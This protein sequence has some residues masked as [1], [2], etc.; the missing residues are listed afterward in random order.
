MN[1]K[2]L[3][4]VGAAGQKG[5]GIGE[6]A[7]QLA[8][9]QNR[10]GVNLYLWT[11]DDAD[12]AG[13]IREKSGLTTETLQTFP[14]LGPSRYAFSPAMVK[15][16]RDT[17]QS[18]SVVHHHGVWACTSYAAFV[19]SKSGQPGRPFILAP[20][21]ELQSW[22]LRRS[23]WKKAVTRRLYVN[24]LLR[25]TA[26]FQALG[27]H[28]VNDIRRLGL[29]N[30]VAVIPNGI[31]EEWCEQECD[32]PA[33]REKY[34][35]PK[36]K[37]IVLFLSRV[38]PKK[39]LPMLFEA[40]RRHRGR[41]SDWLCVVAGPDEFGHARELEELLDS[42]D[43]RSLVRMIGPVY[44]ADKRNA[45]AAADLFVLPSHSEGFPLA[46][47]ESLGAGVPPIV[48]KG[49]PMPFLESEACGWWPDVSAD[50]I[51]RALL[52]STAR[53][54]AELAAIGKAGERLVADK[55]TWTKVAR[56]CVELYSWLEGKGRRPE[57]VIMD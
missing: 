57:F 43:L 35:I 37:R 34:L 38:S 55:F 19:W 48:T 41:L 39:G 45:F 42:W 2:I 9:A 26:C 8:R 11:A 56:Q 4:I 18:F 54:P 3:H 16:I 49:S 10:A 36:D 47:L 31:G 17:D 50:A 15:R 51:A 21:G 52:D 28:E 24:R 13:A 29:T 44:G 32:G 30:P 22:C 20:Q 25:E 53:S 7:V 14:A 27:E 23:R 5:F 12:E 1:S 6:V 40:I 33:F 46:A